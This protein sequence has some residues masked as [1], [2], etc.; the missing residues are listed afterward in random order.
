[1]STKEMSRLM[2]AR[3][4]R[5]RARDRDEA[6][7]KAAPVR[8]RLAEPFQD[9]PPEAAKDPQ[10]VYSIPDS[11]APPAP[12]KPLPPEEGERKPD[13]RRGPKPKADHKRRAKGMTFSASPEE[14]FLLRKYAY[15]QGLG[16][17]EW[18][19]TVLFKAMGQPIPPRS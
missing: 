3:G 7:K 12:K 5:R 13:H 14:A 11:W 16:F 2:K 6:P 4:I 17:S 15:D 18:A 19:R 8:R 10:S 1:M 9:V